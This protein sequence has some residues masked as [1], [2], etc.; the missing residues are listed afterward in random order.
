MLNGWRI[1]VKILGVSDT[2]GDLSNVFAAMELSEPDMILSCGD[3]GENSVLYAEQFVRLLKRTRVY[4]VYGNHDDNNWLSEAR[5]SDGTSVFIPSGAVVKVDGIKIGG[6]NGIW[7]C[8]HN[9]PYYV[10]DEELAHLA[11]RI[12]S[13]RP[14]ILLSH[15]CA[16]GLADLVPGG[17][18]GGQRGFLDAFKRISPRLYICG[19]LHLPQMKV[20]KDGRMIVNIGNTADGD[21]WIF[22]MTE[23]LIRYEQHKL[24]GP[25]D[26]V[27]ASG[28]IHQ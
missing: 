5:N 9:K 16:V 7:A 18:H 22:L 2:H 26:T 24:E 17:R 11:E 15:G 21:F 1:A 10:T 19:H 12:A 20:L 14:D 23:D 3:W 8:S 27:T 6:I 4:T 28:E 13:S 25:V